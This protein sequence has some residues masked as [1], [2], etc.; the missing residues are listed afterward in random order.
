[1]P[2]CKLLEDA[3]SMLK[4]L[5]VG[6]GLSGLMIALSLRD[7]RD[8]AVVDKARS[9]GGR[10]ATRRTDNATFDHGA[11]FYRLKA[12]LREM[13]E[14][15]LERQLVKLW[16]TENQ[17]QHFYAVG[18]MT[19]LAKDL[20]QD[21][22]VIVNERVVGLERKNQKWVVTF[23]SARI[24]KV[25]EVIFTCPTPQ[26]LEIFKVS[27]LAYPARLSE[28]LYSKALV[29][30]IEDSPTPFRF[31]AHGY[32]EPQN[33]SI[34]S[35]ADQHEKGI[36]KVNAITVTLT[37]ETSDQHFD[38]PDEDVIRHAIGELQK[39][40]PNFVPGITQL[41]KWRYCQVQKSFGELFAQVSDG[42][43]LAGDGFGGASLNG[44]ARSADALSKHLAHLNAPQQSVNVITKGKK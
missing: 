21:T 26:T 16:F 15:W 40:Y 24:E 30:L 17:E 20:A 8:V 34:F 33:S 41:K 9:V 3:A 6:A 7:S 14:R 5:V 27:S 25:D 35:V 11:Q 31:Q 19:A 32:V 28:V 12:P 39:I 13:H 38:S 29:L 2:I 44:A 37:A 36:S 4:T 22:R 23:D 10:L 42:L 1:M 43:Y 18:G